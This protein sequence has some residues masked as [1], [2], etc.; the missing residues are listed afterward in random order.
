MECSEAVAFEL[1]GGMLKLIEEDFC[2]CCWLLK[3]KNWLEG[4]GWRVHFVA[5]L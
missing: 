1:V 5:L 3:E 2:L 4:E